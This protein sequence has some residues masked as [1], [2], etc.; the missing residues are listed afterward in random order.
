MGTVIMHVE[1]SSTMWDFLVPDE[2]IM[3]VNLKYVAIL[4]FSKSVMMLRSAFGALPLN[5]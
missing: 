2:L 3:D 1:S 4:G 5:L